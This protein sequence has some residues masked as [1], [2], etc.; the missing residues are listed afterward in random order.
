MTKKFVDM[1][2]V[3]DEAPACPAHPGIALRPEAHPIHQGGTMW[4]W[5]CEICQKVYAPDKPV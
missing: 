3:H 5:R 1:T 2:G 4:F